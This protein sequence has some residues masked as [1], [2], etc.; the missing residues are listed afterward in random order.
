MQKLK[1]L[2]WGNWCLLRIRRS[3]KSWRMSLIL[4]KKVQ[5]NTKRPKIW[6]TRP[7]KSLTARLRNYSKNWSPSEIA[8]SNQVTSSPKISIILRTQIN[9]IPA[10]FRL[11]ETNMDCMRK[12]PILAF[13]TSLS[14]HKHDCPS[15]TFSTSTTSWLFQSPKPRNSRTNWATWKRNTVPLSSSTRMKLPNSRSASRDSWRRISEILYYIY[16]I[17]FD[18]F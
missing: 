17:C 11:D 9:S 12:W 1:K 6:W 8:T 2:L 14:S 18:G 15:T 4:Y 10:K 13:P 7:P 3:N 5:K 16:F